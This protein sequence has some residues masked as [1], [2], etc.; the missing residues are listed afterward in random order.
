MGPVVRPLLA[1]VVVVAC[2]PLTDEE[3]EGSADSGSA[4]GD[5]AEGNSAEGN[6]EGGD[7]VPSGS[8]CDPVSDWDASWSTLE[9]Q[10]LDIVN[11]RRSEGADCGSMGSFGPAPALTMNPS[12]RCAAR[13][14]SKQMVDMAF[15]DHVAPWGE[16][17]WDRMEAAGY[18]YTFAGENIA[19]GNPTA[20][21]TMQQWMDSDGHCSNIMSPDFT[22]IGVG[23]YPGGSYGHMWTQAFGDR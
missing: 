3:L 9:S 18:S 14:H 15:F 11:A 12:L 20:D 13:V 5:S 1:L 10:I 19:A 2:Q 8:F 7:E 6:G 16:E 23:Y 17:P 4:E 21:A 22:E